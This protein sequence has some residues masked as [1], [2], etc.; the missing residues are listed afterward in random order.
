M[1]P[2]ELAE[3][4]EKHKAWVESN[5]TDGQQAD[6]H[7]ADLHGANLYGA[8]LLGVDLSGADLSGADLCKVSL[9]K[10]RGILSVG[11]I[12]SR[13]DTL[14]VVYREHAR[15]YAAGC[16]WGDEEDF[17]GYV[18]ETHGDNVHAQAYRAAVELARVVL[19]G[20]EG[21]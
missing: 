21:A 20:E 7:G 6:L 15:W 19:T 10:A 9:C 18:A 13:G 3:V 8:D 17:L 4:L 1:N 16:F 14:Y 11:P 12:G 5:G 2:A